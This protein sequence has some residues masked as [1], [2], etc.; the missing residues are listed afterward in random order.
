M[1]FTISH[2]AAVLPLRRRCGI[3]L[4]IALAIGS[5]M[6][7]L[8]YFLPVLRKHWPLP[9]HHLISIPL[10]CVP[11]G[12]LLWKLWRPVWT[13]MRPQAGPGHAVEP[14]AWRVLLAL[15]VGSLTHLAW[16]GATHP[17][18]GLGAWLPYW[19]HALF[20]VGH[21]GISLAHLLQYCSSIIGLGI[22]LYVAWPNWRTPGLGTRLP[23]RW[24]LLSAAV[25]FVATV[26]MT[27]AFTWSADDAPGALRHTLRLCAWNG[28]SAMLT[29]AL[30]YPLFWRLCWQHR[31]R[32]TDQPT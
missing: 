28:L 5:M 32:A 18:Y 8:H 24:L 11:V 2:I 25:A 20:H 17:S 13:S 21:V 3:D 14:S 12:W 29:I 22:L 6:P 23:A 26:A 30:F 4:F 1:P 7:D 27:F 16:D 10:F 31:A 19:G 15:A 9:S